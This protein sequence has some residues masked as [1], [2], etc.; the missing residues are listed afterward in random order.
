MACDGME[1]RKALNYDLLP[2]GDGLLAASQLLQPRE[3]QLINTNSG[4]ES[5][6]SPLS[7]RGHPFPI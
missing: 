1:G 3:P 4:K 2:F 6:S 5:V 7:A